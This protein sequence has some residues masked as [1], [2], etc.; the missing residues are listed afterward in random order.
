MPSNRAAWQT[1][2]NVNT[3]EV[4]SAPYTSPR[5]DEIV[6]KNGAVAI[7]PVDWV[8]QE[9]GKMMFTWLKYPFILG[10]DVA[11]EVVEIGPGVTRFKVGDRVVGHANG[12][13]Q[14]CNSPAHGAFQTYTVLTING[15]SPIPSDLSYESAAV[16]PLGVSTAACGLFQKDQLGLQHPSATPKPTGKTLLIWGGSTSVGCN[17]IQLAVAAGYEVITTC[18]PKN[19]DYVKKLGA[20]QAFDYN[21]PTVVADLIRAFEGKSTAGALSIGH[22]AAEN[23][24]DILPKCN[25]DKFISMATYPLP[26]PPPKRFVVLTIMV[27]YLSGL[28][29]IW[30]KSKTRGIRY[31]FI[32]GSTLLYNEVGKAVYEDFLPQAL[33]DGKYV[34]APDP[35]VVG[36]GLEHIQAGFDL[37]RKGVSAKKVVVSL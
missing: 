20:S 28:A 7:N 15:T 23:C 32:F 21:S 10:L 25:G 4:K 1:A 35:Q 11:G 2:P 13:D 27:S 31:N 24:L 18:S 30:V 16:L 37:Q 29:N 5:E 19:F 22:R 33:A 26:Q 12:S 34:A 9:R 36:K 8:I 14:Q 6:I 3:L 17:A